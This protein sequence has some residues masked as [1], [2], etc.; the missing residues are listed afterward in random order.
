MNIQVIKA[1]SGEEMVVLPRADF[2]SI[3]S[4]NEDI[5]DRL[6]VIEFGRALASGTEELIPSAIVD[7]L[8][9]GENAIKVWRDCRGMS[10]ADLSEKA[11]ISLPYLSQLENGERTGTVEKLK[12]IAAALDVLI[13]DLV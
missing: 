7:R 4:S 8:L 11:G 2:E 3:L 6:A 1:P 5:E 13:D 10:R 9:E 12:A